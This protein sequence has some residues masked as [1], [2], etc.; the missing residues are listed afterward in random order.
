MRMES[1][2]LVRIGRQGLLPWACLVAAVRQQ[3]QVVY[4]A[5]GLRHQRAC[6]VAAGQQPQRV[7]P[8]A[9]GQ[10]YQ[11]ACLAVAGRQQSQRRGQ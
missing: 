2:Q 4:P 10:Q 5:V 11:R 7:C 9:A 6:P 3:C 8:A 1:A